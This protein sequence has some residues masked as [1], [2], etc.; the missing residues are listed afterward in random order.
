[1]SYADLVEVI[2]H[3]TIDDAEAKKAQEAIDAVVKDWRQQR[4]EM[5]SQMHE[6]GTGI[7]LL[8]RGI[9][10]VA[11]ATGTVLDPMQN[12]LL[13]LVS[14]TTSLIISTAVALTTASLGILVGVG[15]G[16]SAF[17]YGMQI[18][19]TIKIMADF[20][21]LR[22]SL[23]NVQTR[24]TNIEQARMMSSSVGGVMF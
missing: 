4:Q 24:L 22:M 14:S 8:V 10:T 11:E 23:E 21:A 20:S 16:L 13:G 17:A 19:N 5:V 1:M 6:I 9:R 12:A 2:A 3:I 18:S 7:N 15:L